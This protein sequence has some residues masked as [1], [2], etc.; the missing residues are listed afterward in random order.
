LLRGD[1]YTQHVR[2]LLNALGYTSCGWQLGINVGPT[3]RLLDG[4]AERLIEISDRHGPASIVGFSMG[5]LFA[6]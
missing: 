6:R 2:D 1:G 3:R 5:G 4:S